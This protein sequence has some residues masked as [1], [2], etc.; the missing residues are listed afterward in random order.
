MGVSMSTRVF[1]GL[2]AALVL[3][4][5][6]CDKAQLLAPTGSSVT[7][8]ALT[9]VVPTGG[10]TQV[11]AFVIESAGTPV[12]NGTTVRFT[13]NLGRVDPS[14]VQTSNGYASTTF[15]AGS[16]SGVADVRAISGS[17]GATD[18]GAA[19]P[20]NVVQI[21]VG[22]A[23]VE[24]VILGANPSTV[25]AGG[26]T[27]TLLATVS[28]AAGRLLQGVPVTL[29][30]TAGQLSSSVATTD[31][32]GQARSMLTT[33]AAASVTASAGTKT[34]AATMVTV[35][36]V[37]PPTTATLAATADPVSPNNGHRWTFTATVTSAAGGP[38]P[39]S[40]AWDFGDGVEITTN[41][42]STAHVYGPSTENTARIVRVTI[43]LND[44]SHI[45]AATE[46]LIGDIIP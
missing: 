23:A 16:D 24:T 15:L 39:T 36:P 3:V 40:F 6:A 21:M 38:L 29:V 30:T 41:G 12:Q 14:E 22:A 20:S 28:G 19:S 18:G 33:T 45:V 7:L 13:T 31:Q 35:Q 44:G 42:N 11:T 26:G 17:A 2:L 25:P 9:Q 32:N 46:I 5:A 27:V 4:G 10:S 8:T 34:S 37:V 1:H 43:S